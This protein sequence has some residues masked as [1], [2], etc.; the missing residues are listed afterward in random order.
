MPL[1]VRVD[2]SLVFRIRSLACESAGTHIHLID[3]RAWRD[4][5]VEDIHR[6]AERCAGIRDL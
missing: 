2:P 3:R 4:V 1:S 6:E 5:E